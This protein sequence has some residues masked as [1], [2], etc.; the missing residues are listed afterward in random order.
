[1]SK[2]ENA[3][4]TPQQDKVVTRYD[5]RLQKRKEQEEKLKRDQKVTAG[6]GIAIL[7]AVVILV[8]SFPIRNYMAVHRTF[9]RI[10]GENVSQV[11]F[12]YNYYNTLNQYYSQNSYLLSLF[13]VDM[14]GDLS[15]QMYTQDLS[16]QDFFQ[17]MTVENMRT[18]K[19]LMREAKAE[20]F[21]HDTAE[22]YAK[23][24]EVA[25]EQAAANGMSLDN[26]IKTAYGPYATMNRIEDYVK[27]SIYTSAYYSQQAQNHMPSEEEINAYYAEHP[28]DYDSVDYRLVQV[29]AELPT[30]PTE[31]ADPQPEETE[32]G[33]TEGADAEGTEDGEEEPYEP[34]EAEIEAAMEA[35]RMEAEV[36]E[37]NF[38]ED[39]ATL[40]ENMKHASIS[41]YYGD[42]LFEEGREPGDITTVENSTSHCY[43]VVQFVQ[44]YLDVETPTVNA[45][46]ITVHTEEEL[47]TVAD[48]WA[49]GEATE[50]RFQELYEKYS[51]DTDGL[52]GLYE[53]MTQDGLAYEDLTAWLFDESRAAGDV[54]SSIVEEDGSAYFVYFV[55]AGQPQWYY[56]ARNTLQQTAMTDYVEEITADCEV[57]NVRD[58]LRYLVVE[59]QQSE[60]AA[61]SSAAESEAGSTEA[62]GEDGTEPAES[63]EAAE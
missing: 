17:Q 34:S 48:A 29:N 57:E 32:D 45:R 54:T 42:W 15:T 37:K 33:E 55:G 38:P 21:V 20:G 16:W 31:L 56:S 46:V 11:E 14:T 19:S 22:E 26:F 4:E 61:Q 5:R 44:R 24:Q 59:A 25:R 23:F 18:N 36:T 35:A 6:I 8:L 28:D 53:G 51:E 7:A 39:T 60:A 41:S 62:S 2:K 12:D 49:A 1:M 3:T 27:D 10:G 50:E 58:N 9:V 40:S 63:S 43:Y 13:G 47:Q 52:N 30:E